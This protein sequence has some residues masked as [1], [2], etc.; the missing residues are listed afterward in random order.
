M[1]NIAHQASFNAKSIDKGDN[2]SNCHNL[3]TSNGGF[4]VSYH[5]DFKRLTRSTN[6]ALM[7]SRAVYWSLRTPLGRNGWFYKTAIEW[8]NETGL[9]TKEQQK[10]REVLRAFGFWKEDLKGIP[11]KLWFRVDLKCLDSV[12]SKQGFSLPIE[13]QKFLSKPSKQV[14]P[15][16]PNKFIPS[17]QTTTKNTSKDLNTTNKQAVNDDVL[18]VESVVVFDL[19]E[20]EEKACRNEASSCPNQE[21]KRVQSESKASP[22]FLDSN[23]EA[24]QAAAGENLPKLAISDPIQAQHGTKNANPTIS[25][26]QRF[27]IAFGLASGLVSAHGEARVN[28]VLSVATAKTLG[29]GW[30]IKALKGNWVLSGQQAAG[31]GVGRLL[32]YAEMLDYCNKNNLIGTGKQ[33]KITDYFE[34]IRVPGQEK[35]L[36][37]M[38]LGAS[39]TMQNTQ[40][41]MKSNLSHHTG[42][43][44][45]ENP[46]GLR[47]AYS[48]NSG[49]EGKYEA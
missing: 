10:A 16:R 22:I 39:S 38:K 3:G 17:V 24:Q 48:K 36:W 49:V 15:N 28:E 5:P 9:S 13:C 30:I 29:A 8:E 4:F 33:T 37:K 2:F 35:P 43:T 25:R 19:K 40:N 41:T 1:N 34:A 32:S 42:A 27:G 11:A 47:L 26:L 44:L 7:L 18:A 20:G 12:L 31:A 14:Y 45:N 21:K 46:K 23:Q 6:A